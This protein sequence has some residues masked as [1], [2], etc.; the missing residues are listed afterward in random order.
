MR[1]LKVFSKS[2]S[3]V[4]ETNIPKYLKPSLINLNGKEEVDGNL[5]DLLG[6]VQSYQNLICTQN[7]CQIGLECL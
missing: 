5:D 7:T 4:G 6:A 1:G 3:K 2:L